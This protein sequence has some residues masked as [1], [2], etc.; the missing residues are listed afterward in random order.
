MARYMSKH[1]HT[2]HYSICMAA[3]DNA[4]SDM[5]YQVTTGLEATLLLSLKQSQENKLTCMA[6]CVELWLKKPN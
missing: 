3:V 6:T 1:T 2:H 5:A 4:D